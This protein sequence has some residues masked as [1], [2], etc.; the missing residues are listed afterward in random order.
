MTIEI[1]VLYPIDEIKKSFK[2]GNDTYALLMIS[3]SL[4]HLQAIS[5]LSG[6]L[7]NDDRLDSG[8][9]EELESIKLQAICL[10]N[11]LYSLKNLHFP[12]RESE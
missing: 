3:N 8:L 7:I 4:N 6:A 1:N 9:A 11:E 5:N 10:K 12:L 2:E